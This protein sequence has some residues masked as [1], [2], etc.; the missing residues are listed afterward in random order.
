MHDMPQTVQED[1]SMEAWSSMVN[2]IPFFTHTDPSFLRRVS[3]TTST[4]MFAPGDIVLYTGDMGREMYCVRKGHV[5]VVNS[6][7]YW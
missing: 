4:Y 5:E 6:L 3:L 1:V 2:N 7:T